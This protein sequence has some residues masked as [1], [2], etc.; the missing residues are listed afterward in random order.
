MNREEIS[1]EKA[2]EFSPSREG[3][4]RNRVL[5]RAPGPIP[6]WEPEALIQPT[7]EPGEKAVMPTVVMTFTQPDYRALCRLGQAQAPPRQ[8]WGCPHRLATWQRTSLTVVAPALGGP[9][10]ALVLE[11]L[12]A[13]GAR[14]VLA[15]GWCGS[16]ASA[17]R[18]GHL[19]LPTRAFP[20][21]GT[22]PHYCRDAGMVP[23]HQ[24]LR[25]LL[26]E[27]LGNSGHPWHAGP[28]WSTDAFYRETKELLRSCQAQGFLGIDLEMAALFAVARFRQIALAGLLVVSD[29]LFALQWR[30]AR[31]SQPFRQARKTALTLMLDAAVT[32][33]R[34]NV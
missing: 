7:R 30:P 5:A 28:V 20:G 24:G 4:I 23:P 18:I 27:C 8:V 31:G 33:E 22:S 9:Y 1:G 12:I 2:A 3:Q 29:E 32:A 16:L 15:L 10:A 26:A 25:D 19:I 13:L 21:D 17:V 34:R 14:R 6:A 11:K